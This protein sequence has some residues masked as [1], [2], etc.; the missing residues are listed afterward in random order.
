MKSVNTFQQ[1][2]K[3]A[4]VILFVVSL[5][6]LTLVTTAYLALRA[7]ANPPPVYP[8][9]TPNNMS[10]LRD[11]ATLVSA[12]D[13][14]AAASAVHGYVPSSEEVH[15]L[16]NGLAVAWLQGGAI[17]AVFDH[18]GGCV[19]PL[20][21]PINITIGDG[22]QLDSGEPAR[23]LGL[24]ADQVRS[25]TVTLGDGRAA[26]APAI[27]NFYFV[28]L[29]SD[30]KPWDVVRV[31]ARLLDGSSYSEAFALPSPPP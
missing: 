28:P 8:N 26:S 20:N 12:L 14:P 22:D 4:R 18:V 7:D 21:K 2:V 17:C 11:R 31:E 16:G 13:I 9:L 27:E 24:A 3:R 25:V 5:A 23:V 10:A 19:A 15:R 6:A 29:P 1:R 30:A